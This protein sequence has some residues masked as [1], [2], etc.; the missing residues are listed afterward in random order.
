MATAIIDPPWYDTKQALEKGLLA[1]R[2]K[3]G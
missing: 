1:L 2:P 3:E